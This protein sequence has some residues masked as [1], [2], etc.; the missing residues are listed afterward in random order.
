M[1]DRMGAGIYYPADP[2]AGVYVAYDGPHEWGLHAT[3]EGELEIGRAAM[4]QG[5]W[6]DYTITLPSGL[7]CTVSG[8][9]ILVGQLV[10]N[11]AGGPIPIADRIRDLL[12]AVRP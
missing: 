8:A 7:S 9:S 3:P 6:P 5:E 10:G 12:A 2:D 11:D 1:T 4:V